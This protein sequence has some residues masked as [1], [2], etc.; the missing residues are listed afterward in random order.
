MK[1]STTVHFKKT[2]CFLLFVSLFL[3]INCG[4]N[5]NQNGSSFVKAHHIAPTSGESDFKLIVEKPESAEYNE[6]YDW[7]KQEV[8]LQEFIDEMNNRIE[9]PG[10]VTIKIEECGESNAFYYDDISTISIC[11]EFI[12][13]MIALQDENIDERQKLVNAVGFIFLHEMG[14]ALVAKLD[15]PITGKEENAVDELA[16]LVLTSDTTDRAYFAAVEG[17]M[18]FYSDALNENLKNFD[19]YDTHAPSIERYYDMVAII[20]AAYPESAVDFVGDNDKYK[21][22]QE[23][24]DLAVEQ[25]EKKLNTWKTLLGDAWKE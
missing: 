7:L 14:H 2:S 11:Y 13:E 10:E 5:S 12:D 9:F 3:T 4:Q 17:A 16:M 15:L 18:Q 24:A 1:F 6:L 19:F 22:P 8:V 20:V 21:I 25:Y 23:R